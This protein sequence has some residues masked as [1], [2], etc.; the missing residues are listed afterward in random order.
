MAFSITKR[1]RAVDIP[2]DSFSDI[3]FLLII[4]FILTTSI[5]KMTGFQTELPAGEKS[6]VKQTEK[7]PTVNIGAGR[8][9]L[10]EKSVSLEQLAAELQALQL[11][12]KADDQRV[13]LLDSAPDVEYQ[14]YFEVMAVITASGGVIGI[15]TEDK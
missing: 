11:G 9:L 13:V 8:L 2:L 5:Q 14:L 4:F 1:K 15:L 3:A 7:T 12:T 6:E 10:N